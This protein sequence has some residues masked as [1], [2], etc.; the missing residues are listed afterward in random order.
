VTVQLRIFNGSGPAVRG[1]GQVIVHNSEISGNTVGGLGGEG[2]V[3]AVE[4]GLLSAAD[5]LFFGG[6]SGCGVY[7]SCDDL[8]AVGL[9]PIAALWTRR[10][11]RAPRSGS[12]R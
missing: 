11:R 10:R 8:A 2:L 4:D 6:C 3:V 9:L 1:N 7:Y 5:V 12:N